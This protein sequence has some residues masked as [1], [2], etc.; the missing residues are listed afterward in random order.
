[1]RARAIQGGAHSLALA[2]SPPSITPH[3]E[4][5]RLGI[6]PVSY[7]LHRATFFEYCP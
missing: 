7:L 1:M 6:T 4:R 2:P 5:F 3:R